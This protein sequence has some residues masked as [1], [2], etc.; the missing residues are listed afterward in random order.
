MNKEQL[1]KYMAA[2][3]LGCPFCDSPDLHTGEMTFGYDVAKVYV[4]VHCNRCSKE[5]TD[6]YTLTGVSEATE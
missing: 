4:P 3:G 6:E 2:S 1:A 5:W